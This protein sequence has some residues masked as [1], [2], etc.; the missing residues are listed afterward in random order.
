ML[1]VIVLLCRIETKVLLVGKGEIAFKFPQGF[2]SVIEIGSSFRNI[3]QL[4]AG[5]EVN[6]VE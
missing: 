6:V 3:E 4:F 2:R 1:F 5:G